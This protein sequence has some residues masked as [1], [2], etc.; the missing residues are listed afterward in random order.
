MLLTVQILG[1]QSHE[2]EETY[3]ESLQGLRR[4]R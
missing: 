1:G 2:T 4:P 3:S